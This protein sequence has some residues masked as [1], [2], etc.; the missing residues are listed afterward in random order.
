MT[1][2]QK[3]NGPS[4]QLLAWTSIGVDLYDVATP[5]CS[6]SVCDEIWL[7]HRGDMAGRQS[8]F[9]VRNRHFLL[10]DLVLFV[11]SAVASYFIRLETPGLRELVWGGILLLSIAVPIR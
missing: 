6:S 8:K 5:S 11:I 10:L 2:P 1:R 9:I 7:I 3:G 4:R